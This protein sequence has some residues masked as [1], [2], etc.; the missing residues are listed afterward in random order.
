M[1]HKKKE[2]EY[3]KNKIALV[4]VAVVALILILIALII[5]GPESSGEEVLVDGEEVAIDSIEAEI[6][7]EESSGTEE[8]LVVEEEGSTVV[9]GINELSLQFSTMPDF[10]MVANLPE[11]VLELDSANGE[12]TLDGSAL[13]VENG[14]VQIEFKEFVGSISLES[15]LLDIDGG[16]HK[17]TINGVVLDKNSEIS[18]SADALDYDR[19]FLMGVSFSSLF[20]PEGD[21]TLEVNNKLTYLLENEYIDLA[22]FDGEIQLIPDADEKVELYG[23]AE[24]VGV[25]GSELDLGVE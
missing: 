20:L 3:D 23:T 13:I 24:N 16:S 21:G 12:I 7:E 22:G 10:D 11:V 19:A 25:G 6:V 4:G 18:V 9:D 1:A 5:G 17:V 2:F 14:E 8:S 15:G